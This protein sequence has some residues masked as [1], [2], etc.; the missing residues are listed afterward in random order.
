[1]ATGHNRSAPRLSRAFNRD[2]TASSLPTDV[3]ARGI[4]V[5][6][7]AHVI[8]YDLPDMAGKLHP[9]RGPHRPR[10]QER[11]R[12]HAF[13]PGTTLGADATRAH[14]RHSHGADTGRWQQLSRAPSS[15]H[16]HRPTLPVSIRSE[17]DCPGWFPYP[18]KSWKF[19]WRTA[20]VTVCRRTV[21][22]IRPPAS[23][24][25]CFERGP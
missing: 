20:S 5:Q 2:A 7:I 8:N 18:A 19:S 11:S 14:A 25:A 12:F 10:R 24:S 23:N 21:I 3:A 1:M 16:T 9:P 4:H 6:D 17:P 22:S 15:D 13:R